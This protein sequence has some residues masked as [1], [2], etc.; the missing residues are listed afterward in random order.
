MFL[1]RLAPDVAPATQTNPLASL[2][3]THT[4]S[5]PANQKLFPVLLPLWPQR[6][7]VQNLLLFRSLSVSSMIFPYCKVF[8]SYPLLFA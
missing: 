4:P 6:P 8:V 2:S 3:S 5:E 1:L 7:S